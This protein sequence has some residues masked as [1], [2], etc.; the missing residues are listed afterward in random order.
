[1]MRSR[2]FEHGYEIRVS[3]CEIV[4]PAW[5]RQRNPEGAYFV[6]R[7]PDLAS[8]RTDVPRGQEEFP[9]AWR[10]VSNL[11]SLRSGA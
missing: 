7:I 5:S 8:G 6:S 2:G 10:T 1:M 11:G 9:T 3:S 4:P